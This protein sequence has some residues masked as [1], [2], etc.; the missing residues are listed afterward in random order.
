MKIDPRLIPIDTVFRSLGKVV[1]RY[2]SRIILLPPTDTRH[3][4]RNMLE[5]V[6]LE[7]LRIGLRFS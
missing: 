3:H 2:I 7:I 6:Q 4:R 1:L 5:K